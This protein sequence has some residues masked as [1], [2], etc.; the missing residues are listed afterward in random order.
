MDTGNSS[1]NV[2]IITTHK[3]SWLLMEHQSSVCKAEQLNLTTVSK[4]VLALVHFFCSSLHAVLLC[5]LALSVCVFM[6]AQARRTVHSWHNHQ[7]SLMTDLNLTQLVHFCLNGSSSCEKKESEWLMM[8]TDCRP[9]TGY[10]H[11]CVI[12][13]I[14]T[15]LCMLTSQ[16]EFLLSRSN[17]IEGRIKNRKGRNPTAHL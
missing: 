9:V 4:T 2:K 6:F 8:V 13:N 14:L 7:L 16:T 10:E 5:L 1:S 11:S 15:H 12:V 17:L 3:V